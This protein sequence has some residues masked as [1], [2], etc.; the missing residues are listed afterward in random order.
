MPLGTSARMLGA[1]MVVVALLGLT[2]G[3]SDMSR[4]GSAD[5][6]KGGG[7]R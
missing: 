4:F 2:L 1:G 5:K 7:Q 6:N 3:S